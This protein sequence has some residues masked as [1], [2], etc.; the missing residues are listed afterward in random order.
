MTVKGL[1]Q[2]VPPGPVRQALG[3]RFMLHALA[4]LSPASVRLNF[5]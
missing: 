2:D 5:Q 3:P 1:A 4:F